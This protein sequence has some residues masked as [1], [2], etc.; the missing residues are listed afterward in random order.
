[1]SKKS[2]AEHK[3]GKRTP[4]PDKSGKGD[5][6]RTPALLNGN[7]V[8][9]QTNEVDRI[10][11]YYKSVNVH[12]SA[13]DE[14][15]RERVDYADDLLRQH[16]YDKT[17]VRGMLVDKYGVSYECAKNYIRYA[18]IIHAAF[19][20]V[21]VDYELLWLLEETKKK[22]AGA[23]DKEGNKDFSKLIHAQ[24]CLLEDIDK[25]KQREVKK[26]GTVNVNIVFNPDLLGIKDYDE[27]EE[28]V[29]IIEL[30]RKAKRRLSGLSEMAE[31]AEV[32]E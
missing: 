32:V 2:S 22:I 23:T 12:L 11:A 16:D 14:E 4:P 20:D 10:L 17:L 24:R 28:K 3:N 27:D 1:M 26:R 6:R 19:M 31:E 21:N 25:R 8:P 29:R 7:N 9:E 15:I 30:K 13:K 18:E 5:G